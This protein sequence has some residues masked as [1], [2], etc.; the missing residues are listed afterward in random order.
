MCA[1]TGQGIAAKANHELT[2]KPGRSDGPVFGKLAKSIDVVVKT[3]SIAILSL[4]WMSISLI[5]LLA[6]SV[7]PA[8]AENGDRQLDVFSTDL[9]DYAYKPPDPSVV[10]KNALPIYNKRGQ[11]SGGFW[12]GGKAD[13]GVDWDRNQNFRGR[14]VDDKSDGVLNLRLKF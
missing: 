4:S 5:S 3:R 2:F 1:Y 7:A 8:F 13:T 10:P 9:N 12:V 11:Q 14:S 6:F